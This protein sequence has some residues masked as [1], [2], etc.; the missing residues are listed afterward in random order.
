MK[1]D[2]LEGDRKWSESIAVVRK[3]FVEEVHKN[4]GIKAKARKVEK[5]EESYLIREPVASYSTLFEGKNMPLRAEN[6]Y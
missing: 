2:R 6:T 4:L 1:N 3:S 5:V